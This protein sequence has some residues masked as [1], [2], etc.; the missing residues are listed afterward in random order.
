MKDSRIGESLWFI[1]DGNDYDADKSEVI[2]YTL[3]HV[4]VENEVVKKAL[5]SSIQRDGITSS[6]GSA[7][8][9]ID[10]GNIFQGYVGTVDGDIN[11]TACTE[12]GIT[13]EGVS[14]ESVIPATWVGVS[15]F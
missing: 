6:L 5:A 15:E 2:Y 12:D 8:S 1:W 10:R 14:V 3:D 9:M 13:Y 7:F 4:D 11:Y